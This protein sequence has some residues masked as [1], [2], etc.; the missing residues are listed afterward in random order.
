MSN[1]KLNTIPVDAK[2]AWDLYVN[3]VKT[4]FVHVKALNE[5][6][7]VGFEIG[8]R[9][10]GYP[11]PAI[12]EKGGAITI[13]YSFA[14]DG[15]LLIGLL[16]KKRPNLDTNPILEA[17]GGLVDPGET[18]TQTQVRE[19]EEESGI[20]MIAEELPGFTAW[21]RLYQFANLSSGEGAGKRYVLQIPFNLLNEKDGQFQFGAKV[22]EQCKFSP[23]VIFLPWV[24]ASLTCPDNIALGGIVAL[25]AL[26]R[27]KGKF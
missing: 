22:V 25:L 6:F 26:L 2:H 14:E 7:G 8:Q 19:T 24:E 9:P 17:V 13:F 23:D 1:N 11:G 18:H 12:Y 27:Q 16:S 5:K 3:G 20:N 4:P 15:E 10:E 21:N